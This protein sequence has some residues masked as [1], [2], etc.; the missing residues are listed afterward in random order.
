MEDNYLLER[1]QPAR[2]N[3]AARFLDWIGER[4]FAGSDDDPPDEIRTTP[5]ARQTFQGFPETHR[6]AALAGKSVLQYRLERIQERHG[7]D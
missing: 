3:V 2:W 4:W 7:E 5:E 6:R 1:A